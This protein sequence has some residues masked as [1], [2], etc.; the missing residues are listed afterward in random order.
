MRASMRRSRERKVFYFG[1]V[2]A[3]IIFFI[4]FGTS[5]TANAGTKNSVRYK[6][7]TSVLV[8]DGSS[9]W[10]IAQT[11]MTEEYTSTEEYID[12]VKEINHMCD[13]V[14]YEGSYLCVPYYSSE[15]K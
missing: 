9:L 12:E 7:Y 15:Y 2:L 10:E 1:I 4:I 5:T 6:Y 8:K 3:V 14:L 11:Y 13:N